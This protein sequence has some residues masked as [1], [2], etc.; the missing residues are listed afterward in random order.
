MKYLYVI[1]F[2]MLNYI[3]KYASII[4]IYIIHVCDGAYFVNKYRGWLRSANVFQKLMSLISM[5]N[6]LLEKSQGARSV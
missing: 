5:Q 6:N 2:V 3:V 1:S 4:T